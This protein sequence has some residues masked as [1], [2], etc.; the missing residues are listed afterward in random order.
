[1]I[2]DVHTHIFPDAVIQHRE[3]FFADEPAFRLLYE[4]PK[5]RLISPEELIQ[6]M[7]EEGVERSVTFGFPFRQERLWR[8]TSAIASQQLKSS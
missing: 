5:S 7:E 3:D 6:A 4:S 1:M 8:Y 2:L